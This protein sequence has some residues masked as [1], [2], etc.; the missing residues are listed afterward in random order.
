MSLNNNEWYLLRNIYDAKDGQI[1]N[2]YIPFYIDINQV[3]EQTVYNVG[4]YVKSPIS[5][6]ENIVTLY[7]QNNNP[8]CDPLKSGFQ[9]N[10]F[11]GRDAKGAVT[12]TIERTYTIS[13]S[14]KTNTCQ[15][16]TTWTITGAQGIPTGSNPAVLQQQT[17]KANNAI[18]FRLNSTSKCTSISGEIGGV[19][20]FIE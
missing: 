10:D 2:F 12:F 6:G 20:L 5:K 4:W 1:K 17:Y 11:K 16:S 18:G 19:I 15:L 14:I 7:C 9:I 13:I 3:G 8:A